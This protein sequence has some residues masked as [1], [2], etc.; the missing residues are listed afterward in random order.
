[1][2]LVVDPTEVGTVAEIQFSRGAHRLEGW[3]N[4]L[5]LL[6]LMVTWFSLGLASIA[7]AQSIGGDPKL[8]AQPF[9]KQWADGFPAITAIV[10]GTVHIPLVYNGV[11]LF[12]FGEVALFDFIVLGILVII[13]LSIQQIESRAR[14]KAEEIS[15]WLEEELYELSQ[16]SLV[17]SLGPGPGNKQPQWAVEVH[18]AIS[19]LSNVLAEVKSIIVDF[20]T[21]IEMQRDS[22]NKV[23]ENTDRV[24]TSVDRL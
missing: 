10:I 13:T 11:R 5:V 1:M 12:T 4:G 20:G 22:I 15:A 6:P 21:T 3:R 2:H 17:R 16:A 8:V 24:A 14:K 18:T 19:K 7:Y 23:I 9:L